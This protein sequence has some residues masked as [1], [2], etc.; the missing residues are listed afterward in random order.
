MIQ[1]PIRTPAQIAGLPRLETVDAKALADAAGVA[2]E[3]VWRRCKLW[4]RRPRDPRALPYVRAL[5]RPYRI[6][7]ADALRFLQEATA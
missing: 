2:V 4:E 6:R 5:G 3:T 1:A 7:K